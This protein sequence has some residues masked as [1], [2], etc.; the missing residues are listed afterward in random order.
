MTERMPKPLV[1]VAGKPMIEYALDRLLT[2]GIEE[3]VVNVSHRKYFQEASRGPLVPPG[4]DAGSS[5]LLATRAD[6][7][8][9]IVGPEVDRWFPG[10][11]LMF[12]EAGALAT[13]AVGRT[14]F[15]SGEKLEPIYLRATTF[16]KAPPRRV[17][18][19]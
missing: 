14:D 16:V 2:Y 4:F 11:R 18:P 9:T 12:P 10:A 6:A 5:A 3:V 13:L 17:L 7:G 19:Q 15:V 1:P 8:E